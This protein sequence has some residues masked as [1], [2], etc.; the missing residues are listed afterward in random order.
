MISPTMSG[1]AALDTL[2]LAKYTYRPMRN[3]DSI[4]LVY[5][6][7]PLDDSA[8]ITISIFRAPL[9]D[10]KLEY[11]ALSYT[12][13]NQYSKQTVF[14]RNPPSVLEVTQNC[15][16]ALR[17]LRN[18]SIRCL[19]IDAICINQ[20]DDNERSAQVRMMDRVFAMASRVIVDLGEETP[21]SRLL[22][23]ELVEADQSNKLTGKYTRPRPSDKIIQELECLFR[24]PW[25][26]RVWVIQEV[27]ANPCVRIMCGT[28]QSSWDALEACDMGYA[29]TRVSMKED[30]PIM[31]INSPYQ[32]QEYKL[33]D[34]LWRIL[35]NTRSLTASDPR[36]RVFALLYLLGS[37]LDI[38]DQLV[39]YSQSSEVIFTRVGK[40]LLS[41]VGLKLLTA[42][43][44][45]HARDMPSWVPDWSQKHQDSLS[46]P[47]DYHDQE[48]I[49]YEVVVEGAASKTS[50]FIARCL[51]HIEPRSGSKDPGLFELQSVG[52][53]L[54]AL[55]LKGVRIGTVICQSSV[56]SFSNFDDAKHSFLELLGFFHS[57]HSDK[58]LPWCTEGIHLPSDLLAGKC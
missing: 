49:D 48:F 34:G 27:I 40:I 32:L 51:G 58:D 33:P 18:D 23:D 29:Q 21:G 47:G 11:E 25:F 17:R 38:R 20:N 10:A 56:F 35:L 14:C 52:K 39:D 8:P 24:R 12:W 42:A 7:H 53:H 15:Y 50:Q 43:R 44:R 41:Q 19:W 28:H 30:P 26:W 57:C 6:H 4:R 1:S 55:K 46:S 3:G 2:N 31:R 37:G 22:F 16:S 9:S 13:G 5:L 36:D 54:S 45:G